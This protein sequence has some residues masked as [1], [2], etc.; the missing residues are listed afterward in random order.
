[1]RFLFRLMYTMHGL[2]GLTRQLGVEIKLKLD[3]LTEYLGIYTSA[4]L[5]LVPLPFLRAFTVVGLLA[6]IA[7]V[8]LMLRKRRSPP[9]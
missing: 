7:V 4:G 2:H 3:Y 8:L 6:P 9:A 1:M 5:E